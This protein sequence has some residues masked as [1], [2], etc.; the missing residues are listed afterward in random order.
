MLYYPCEICEERERLKKKSLLPKN[1]KEV[2]NEQNVFGGKCYSY[3]PTKDQDAVEYLK[4]ENAYL[5]GI[6]KAYERFLKSKGYMN[7]D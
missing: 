5:R 4:S 6:I 7:N 1:L 2:I 3:E